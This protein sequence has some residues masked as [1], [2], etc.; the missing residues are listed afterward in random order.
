MADIV[1]VAQ[2]T[3]YAFSAERNAVNIPAVQADDVLLFNL[4]TANAHALGTLPA[5]VDQIG[6]TQDATGG[7]SSTSILRYTCNG[8]EGATFNL[9]SVYAAAESGG[10][11]TFALRGLD[12]ADIVETVNQTTSDIAGVSG[13]IS[14]GSVSPVNDNCTILFIAGCDP[15]SSAVSGTPDTSP[16]ATEIF[17]GKADS[18]N[19]SYGYVQKYE[20]A[21]AAPISLDASIDYGPLNFSVFTIA[22]NNA[23]SGPQVTTADNI[24][25]EGDTFTFT[26]LG[27]ALA[28]TTATLN[29][30][31][32]GTITDQGLGVYSAA[33]PLIADDETADLV[34][35]VDSTTVST[36]ISYTN[37]Y[38]YDFV[39]GVPAANSVLAGNQFGSAQPVEL[40]VISDLDPLVATEDWSTHN[41]MADAE[42]QITPV[43]DG[44]TTVTFGYFVT[45]TGE[46]GTFDR[47]FTIGDGGVVV[48]PPVEPPAA[49]RRLKRAI[50]V[51]SMMRSLRKSL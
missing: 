43:A 29:G 51:T 18:G 12:L 4:T 9:G 28:P 15:A 44:I 33:A 34:I 22:L 13:T 30:A 20:Q 46:T 25:S 19:W 21:T 45:E 3:D 42:G 39:H 2:T 1:G 50:K 24:T 41:F 23:V 8:T 31:D 16:S 27:N 48:E 26:L 11:L 35:S 10:V 40:K 32:V 36:V 37:S 14:G 6:T 7:D 38:L 49:S 47:V 17:D 5:G